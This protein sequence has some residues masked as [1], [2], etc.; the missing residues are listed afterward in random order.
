MTAAQSLQPHKD[1]LKTQQSTIRHIIHRQSIRGSNLKE[2]TVQHLEY[3]GGDERPE[4]QC[5][6]QK[7]FILVQP[8]LDSNEVGEESHCFCNTKKS[9]ENDFSEGDRYNEAA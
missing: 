1:P 2:F 4:T 8:S 5:H 3:G 7:A 9:L 6:K